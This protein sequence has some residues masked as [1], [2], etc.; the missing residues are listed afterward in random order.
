MRM[1]VSV[2]RKRRDA[3]KLLWM[4]EDGLGRGGGQ[5]LMVR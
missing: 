5:D 3:V 2:S 1:H 4:L